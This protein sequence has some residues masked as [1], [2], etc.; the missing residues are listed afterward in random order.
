[1]TELIIS[2]QPLAYL[3]ALLGFIWTIRKE[4]KEDYLRLEKKLET[5]RD[6]TNSKID[7]WRDEATKNM[8]IIHEEMKEFH[9][10]LVSIEEKSKR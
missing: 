4:S 2:L 6:E 5:W 8:N 3:V 7:L 9:G 1:M 10:R